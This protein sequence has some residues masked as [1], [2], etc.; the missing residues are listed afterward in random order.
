ME[1][2]ERNNKIIQDLT[3]HVSFSRPFYIWMGFLTVSLGICVYAYCRQL[4]VGLG[5]TGM[6]D[7]VSWGLYISNFVFF[8]A[9]SLIGML[10][11]SI[12]GLIG[13]NWIRSIARIAEIIAFS[14]AAVAGLV[15]IID[16]GRPERIFTIFIY[17][18]FQS[19]IVWD[20]TLVIVYVIITMLLYI[21]NLI[22]DMALLR[23][24]KRSFPLWQRKVYQHL[25]FNWEGTLS[26]KKLL[27]K[28]V[29][30]LLILAIP[31]AFAIHTV[32]SW[33]FALTPRINWNSTIFGPYFITGA[34]VSGVSALIIV[35]FILRRICKLDDYITEYHFNKLS[36]LL[37]I[38]SWVYLYFN[39]NE[40]LV[41]AYH[42]K[43][44]EAVLF[45]K[46]FSGNFAILF[47]LV[48]LTGVLLP[49]FLPLLR[50]FR[51]IKPLFILS[52]LVVAGSWLKRYLIVIPTMEN[53]MLPIQNVPE[54][55]IYYTPTATEI[56]ITAGT[57]LIVVMLISIL[58]KI[59]PVIPVAQTQEEM[60]KGSG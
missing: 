26:Q 6:R 8:V 17:G 37:I 2:N 40:Y 44:D 54:N 13:Q 35:T 12:L 59:F 24:D 52:I 60:N 36:W 56:T 42:V 18:R 27:S 31:V 10:I 58:S 34:F 5:V 50:F 45:Q 20:V 49:S 47:W 15:I 9:I 4:K 7:Y 23:E 29:K 28:I 57:L 46:L 16:M 39:I 25:S 48:Q 19:P 53:P 22:P 55:F 11:S 41:P 21:V 14:F 3:R 43:R 30:S 38:V 33:L 51:R 32:T 1:L